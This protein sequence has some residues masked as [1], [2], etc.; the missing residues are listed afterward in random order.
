MNSNCLSRDGKILVSGI[1]GACPTKEHEC[2]DIFLALISTTYFFSPPPHLNW[3][4]DAKQQFMSLK[5]T[6]QKFLFFYFLSPNLLFPWRRVELQNRRHQSHF[7]CK[8]VPLNLRPQRYPLSH[9]WLKTFL[10]TWHKK[11]GDLRGKTF[12]LLIIWLHKSN[13][14]AALRHT[15][16]SVW[17]NR[18]G[19]IFV[20][21]S[22]KMGFYK[23]THTMRWCIRISYL[24]N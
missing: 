11:T 4:D 14:C 7:F 23:P 16:V 5:K 12:L 8:N 22:N 13:K 19:L 1:Y 15:T 9:A 24:K 3:S 10:K 20:L 21:E 2:D 6:A 18:A 17:C